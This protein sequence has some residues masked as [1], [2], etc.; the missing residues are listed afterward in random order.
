MHG[1][2]LCRRLKV[3]P[4]SLLRIRLSW[5]FCVRSRQ[6]LLVVEPLLLLLLLLEA[7]PMKPPPL[8][9]LSTKGTR[10]WQ[11]CVRSARS[12]QTWNQCFGARIL[13]PLL[14]LLQRILQP[15]KL[16]CM[17]RKY[18]SVL[19]VHVLNVHVGVWS[20]GVEKTI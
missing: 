6:A 14:C 17:R 3:Q 12:I 2:Q 7:V 10:A 13:H 4:D 20:A 1:Q 18:V 8:D 5:L 16:T 19:I 9:P 15:K 11:R